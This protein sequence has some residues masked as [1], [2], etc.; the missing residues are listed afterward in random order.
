MK[1]CFLLFALSVTFFGCTAPP[2]KII[3]AKTLVVLVEDVSGSY[4]NVTLD[5]IVITSLFQR[6]GSTGGTVAYVVINEQSENQAVW[7]TSIE[8]C[9]TT[10]TVGNSNIYSKARITYLNQQIV[11]SFKLLVQQKT[12]ELLTQVAQHEPAQFTDV[13]YALELCRTTCEPNYATYNKYIVLL[14]DMRL[15]VPKKQYAQ[16]EAVKVC[17]ASVL[18][19]RAA[20]SQDSLQVLFP[21]SKEVIPFTTVQSA[22]NFINTKK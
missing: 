18:A 6:V 11:D 3:P 21:D 13:Q 15:D 4:R 2:K 5:S 10:T 9:D 22:F 8:R 19:V 1:K 16:L 14:S 7:L 17:G 20:I 12:S